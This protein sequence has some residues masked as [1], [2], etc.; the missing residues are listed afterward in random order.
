MLF[1]SVVAILVVLCSAL[2]PILV[3][4]GAVNRVKL[5]LEWLEGDT[6]SSADGRRFEVRELE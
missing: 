2:I 3:R 4:L 6:Y 1:R 5:V